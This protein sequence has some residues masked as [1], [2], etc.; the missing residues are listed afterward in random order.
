LI[1]D[2]FGDFQ[3]G[4]QLPLSDAVSD[5]NPDLL[6]VACDLRHDVDFLEGTEFRREHDVAREILPRGRGHGDCRD[7]GSDRISRFLIRAAIAGAETEDDQAYKRRP[8]GQWRA[9][10]R[11]IVVYR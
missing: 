10:W 2:H 1:V 5:I 6:D 3:R 7:V 8:D 11:P 4:K 9:L